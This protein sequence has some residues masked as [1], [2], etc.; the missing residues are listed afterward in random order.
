MA[1]TGAQNGTGI[2]VLMGGTQIGG[3]NSHSLTL[4]NSIIDITNKSSASYRELLADEGTQS[5]DLSLDLTFNS[6]VTAAALRVAAGDKSDN[7]FTI[8]M[9]AGTMSFSGIVASYAD[10]S[11]D[12]DKL[13]ASVSI[14]STGTVTWF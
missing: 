10:T 6:E 9:P 12:G 14:Q 2:F 7:V 13:S 4:N 3:Q 5:V 11:P 1:T 8:V